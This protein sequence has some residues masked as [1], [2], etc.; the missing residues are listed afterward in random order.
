MENKN[1][2]GMRTPLWR[3]MTGKLTSTPATC[4]FREPTMLLS[5]TTYC[6]HSTGRN[7]LTSSIMFRRKIHEQLIQ[8]RPQR[9]APR[10]GSMYVCACVQQT[11][12]V[13]CGVYCGAVSAWSAACSS[14]RCSVWWQ[15]TAACVFRSYDIVFSYSCFHKKAGF[16]HTQMNHHQTETTGATGYRYIV[17]EDDVIFTAYY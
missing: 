9:A 8:P 4:K 10:A 17:P 13:V 11:R 16:T 2:K 3:V 7:Q 5:A 14:G 12:N 1:K 15:C 6:R